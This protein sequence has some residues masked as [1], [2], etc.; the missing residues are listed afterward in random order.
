MSLRIAINAQLK[1]TA[2]AGG[3]ETVLIGLAH[4]LGELDGPEEYVLIAPWEEPDWLKPYLGKN[5]SVVR[6]PKLQ[7]AKRF[8]LPLTRLVKSAVRKKSR[9]FG[10]GDIWQRMSD[11]RRFYERLGCQVI[12][13]PYQHF[14]HTSVPSIFNPHD[15]QHVHYPQFFSAADVEWREAT[16]GGACRAANKVVAFS[17]WVKDDIVRHYQI[18]PE[19]VQVI[20]WPPPTRSYSEPTEETLKRVKEKYG[21]PE[22]FAF[23]PAM[24]W[25][26]KN[27]I[28]LLEALA[29]IRDSRGIRIN[30]VC[31]GKQTEFFQN[32]ARKMKELQLSSQVR[33]LGMV[34]P[35]DLRAI[36]RLARFMVFPSLFEGAGV[37]LVEAWNE[38]TPATC[39][40]VT[41]IAEQACDAALLFDP[42]S[43][44]AIANAVE[45]I[46]TDRS[47]QETLTR[48]GFE[49]LKNFNWETTAKAYRAVYRRAAGQPLTEEDQWILTGDQA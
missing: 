31:T 14:V 15:L 2:G 10:A 45:K 17:Q 21:L 38:G 19:K 33:F 42:T 24:T 37:P 39:A 18:Q 27:H 40:A 6:G 29:L 35:A 30:L 5:Q 43:V 9:M 7:A 44:Q 41:S 49:Q 46:A 20:R 32:I 11:N 4:A 13:F 12:H 36:Y 26:H 25:E 34:P 28:R 3:T 47:L 1:P 22:K 23:Y 48:L 16:Y 8:L